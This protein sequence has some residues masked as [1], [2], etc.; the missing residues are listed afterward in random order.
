MRL[1]GGTFFIMK[2]NIKETTFFK[3]CAATSAHIDLKI[4]RADVAARTVK[5]CLPNV[6]SLL[7]P[8]TQ[9]LRQKVTGTLF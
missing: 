2:D 7:P 4:K 6:V 9:Y 8:G 5:S 1:R 3:V